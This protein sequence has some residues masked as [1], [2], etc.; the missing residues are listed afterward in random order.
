MASGS[1]GKCIL[2]TETARAGIP[3][4]FVWSRMGVEAGEELE[5]IVR[6]KERER[7]AAG[8]TFLWGIGSSVGKAV[9]SLLGMT[10]TPEVI[11]SPILGAPRAVDS[12]PEATA[13]WLA[14]VGLDGR[15]VRLPDAAVVTSR[16]DP[17]RPQ[18]PRYALVC[19]SDA[20]LALEDLGEL[21]FEALTNLASG[22]PVGASQV[23]AVVRRAPA[24]SATRSRRY[25]VALRARLVTPYV[26]RLVDPVVGGRRLAAQEALAVDAIA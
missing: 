6:R 7:N 3:E 13:R 8:G 18:T 16:W 11:F 5:R 26:L 2:M 25:Q 20:P 19:S 9:T 22:A 15:Q 17:A 24:T 12:A 10:S 4:A 1:H 14:G 23:T 21:S